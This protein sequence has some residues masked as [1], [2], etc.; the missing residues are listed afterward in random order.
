MQKYRVSPYNQGDLP[1]F[2][3]LNNLEMNE[4]FFGKMEK[5][6]S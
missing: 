4:K 2:C 5:M 1:A 3:N 6:F